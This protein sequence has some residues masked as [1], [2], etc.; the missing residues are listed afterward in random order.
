MASKTSLLP[1]VRAFD[2][3]AVDAG[4]AEKP[5]LIAH[6]DERQ[7]NWLH[8]LCA[9]EL[10]GRDPADSI[11]TADVL[12]A[13]GID[14]QDHAFTE[15]A[16][17]ATP[18]WFC[19]AFGRNLALAEHLLKLGADP[20]HSLFAAAYNDDDDAIDLLIRYGAPVEDPSSPAA[21]PFLAA[22]EWSH[23]RAADALARHGANVNARN[24]KGM[25]AFHCMLKKGTDFEPF[26]M[27]ATRGAR[28]DIPGPDGVTAAEIM[29]RKRD[30]RFREL[31]A[32]LGS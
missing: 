15:G 29:A 19:V 22:V 12:L 4:L 10:K 31:A 23:F 17:K 1:R 27:L 26:A 25:T 24:A 21:S 7:R 13:R 5:G 16:W 28:A 14:L 32:Q 18:V 30:P 11:R 8:I 20:N 6:R 9:T 3:K 2:W